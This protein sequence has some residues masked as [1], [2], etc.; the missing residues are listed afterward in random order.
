MISFKEPFKKS[1]KI[2]KKNKDI[3]TLTPSLLAKISLFLTIKKL[4]FQIEPLPPLRTFYL[5]AHFF[6][7]ASIRHNRR[8]HTIVN[9]NH[10]P[11]LVED[12][13]LFIL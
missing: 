10:G 8:S 12:L 4:G 7:M 6:L 13:I 2:E 1:L 9:L 11:G 5:F 3:L